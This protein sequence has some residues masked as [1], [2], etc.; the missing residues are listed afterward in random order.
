MKRRQVEF[1]PEAEADMNA[2]YDWIAE[3][4]GHAIALAYVEA[5][6]KYCLSLDLASERGTRRD[7]IRKNLRILGF[8]RR[9]TIAFAVEDA[10]VVILRSFYGGQDWENILSRH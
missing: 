7:D 5:L 2:I 8:R 6:E 3:Q 1:T 10:R 4:A 9:V